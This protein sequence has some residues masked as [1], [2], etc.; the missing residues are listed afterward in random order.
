MEPNFDL[1]WKRICEHA[2]DSFETKSGR[3]FTYE[4][5]GNAVIP[6]RTDYRLGKGDFQ[7]AYGLHPVDGPGD[8]NQLV[9][10]PAYIWAVLHDHRIT[11][12]SNE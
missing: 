6:S 12:D 4:I 3:P 5:D 10:G 7:K 9:R 8:L 1:I 2:G 11:G